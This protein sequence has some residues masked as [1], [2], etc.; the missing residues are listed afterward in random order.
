MGGDRTFVSCDLG[1]GQALEDVQHGG[2]TCTMENV[3]HGGR[4]LT[5]ETMYHEGKLCIMEGGLAP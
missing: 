4:M 5:L 1:N 2:R 3:H